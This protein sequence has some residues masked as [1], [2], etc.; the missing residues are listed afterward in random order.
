MRLE[1]L[2]RPLGGVFTGRQRCEE[3]VR[4]ALVAQHLFHRD[5][6]Y[7][8][9]D[10][11]VQIIDEYTGRVMADRSWEHG[12]HQL[13][14]AKEVPGGVQCTIRVTIER[15]GGDKPAAV[16]EALTRYLV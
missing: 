16:V 15:E 9:A 4:Q 8:V 13:I 2:A 5:R 6:H 11:K 10:G 14:E 12:L 3:L 1:D 7:L